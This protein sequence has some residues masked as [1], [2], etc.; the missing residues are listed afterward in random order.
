MQDHIRLKVNQIRE[1]AKDIIEIEWVSAEADVLLPAF[2]AGAHLEFQFKEEMYRSY[3]LAN[4][5]QERHRYVIAV[6][7]SAE[8]QGGSRHVHQ[9][10]KRGDCCSAT[11]P[12]NHFPLDETNRAHILI[13][14]GV[15][16]TPILAMAYRLS[17]LN[18]P[19][20]LHYCSR[21]QAHAAYREEIQNL[22][23]RTDNKV[24]FY[25]DQTPNGQ[26]LDL[27]QLCQHADDSAHFYCCGPKGMLSAF[28]QATAHRPHTAHLEYFSAKDQAALEGGFEIELARSNLILKVPAGRSI[29]DVVFEAGISVPSSCREGICGSCETALLSG[30]A[31]HRDALLSEDEKE[32]N[33]TMMICC[34]GAKS[35]TLVLD[36]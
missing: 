2:T 28:E 35:K 10:L 8:S 17:V 7:L 4:D 15:G 27:T 3:S 20:V 25:F 29:L 19:W 32:S 23:D 33:Q 13:A 12:R 1:I 9:F 16:I 24:N 36:L 14:G 11:V 18:K 22:A 5:P 6:H 30:E 34:S 21:T 26:R 31:D